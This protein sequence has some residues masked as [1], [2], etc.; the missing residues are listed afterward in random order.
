MK[1][2]YL[3]G[4]LLTAGLLLGGC[5]DDS[6]PSEMAMYKVSLT[7]LTYAQP[8]SPMAALLHDKTFTLFNIG[9]T[10]SGS[11][12]QLAEGGDNSLLLDEASTDS[13]V[14]AVLSGNRLIL[15][16]AT[17]SVT[18]S[19]VNTECISVA[20]MLVNT[21]D[22]FSGVSCIDVSSLQKGTKTSMTLIAY[23]SGSE[24]NSETAGTI[25]GPAGGGEGYN[26]ARDDHDFI[27]VHSGV[28]TL[29][30]GLS[31]S[32][33]TMS[34]RWDNPTAKITIERLQ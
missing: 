10:A 27:T 11:L 2:L 22:A 4:S 1:T 28:V 24:T 20:S 30:D 12:E 8:M 3:A 14:K 21:N 5:G 13:S 9:V 17:D 29:D 26:S 7:N 16:G 23:D 19:G 25:P 18:L 34:H 32:A 33:L 6:D 31:D 15:P